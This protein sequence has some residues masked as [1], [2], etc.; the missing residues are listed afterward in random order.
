MPARVA[1][2]TPGGI[3]IRLLLHLIRAWDPNHSRQQRLVAAAFA[4]LYAVIVAVT[5][6]LW[7]HEGAPPPE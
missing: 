7:V 2:P 5:I 6:A 3:V 1:G 4:I